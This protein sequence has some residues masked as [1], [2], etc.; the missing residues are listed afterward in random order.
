MRKKGILKNIPCPHHGIFLIFF[1]PCGYYYV[2]WHNIL[3]CN[4]YGLFLNEQWLINF[5]HGF[6]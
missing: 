2:A 5:E 1:L 4:I 3:P 6:G